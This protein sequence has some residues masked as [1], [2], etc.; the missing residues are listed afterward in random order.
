MTELCTLDYKRLAL[1][2]DEAVLCMQS[3]PGFVYVLAARRVNAVKIGFTAD[4]DRRVK[5][6]RAM[7]PAPLVIVAV[8][9]G[10]RGDEAILHRRFAPYRLHDEWYRLTPECRQLLAATFKGATI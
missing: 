8:V 5:T 4:V 7:S 1:S 2:H 9:E 3:R 6:L 10:S